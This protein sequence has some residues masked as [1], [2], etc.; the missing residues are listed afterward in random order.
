MNLRHICCLFVLVSGLVFTII[1]CDF[2][3]INSPPDEITEVTLAELLPTAL[4]Q[5]A[6][7]QSALE[8]R[9]T[10]IFSQVLKEAQD[11]SIRPF[12]SYNLAPATFDDYWSKGYYSGS[13]LQARTILE[14]AQKE[15]AGPYEAVAKIILAHEFGALTSEFGDIPFSQAAKGNEFLYPQY[16]TQENVYA[17]I[18]TLLDEAI[19][20]IELGEGAG[21][22]IDDMLYAGNMG[23]WK[24]FAYA[25]KARFLLH[26][27]NKSPDRFMEILEILQTRTFTSMEEQPK[28]DWS[29][30]YIIGLD[31]PFYTFVEERPWTIQVHENFVDRLIANNDPRLEKIAVEEEP[32]RW[33]PYT[34]SDPFKLPFF[35]PMASIPVLSMVEIKFMEAE[36][37]LRTGS[38]F[39]PITAA[40]QDAIHISFT[41]LGLNPSDHA[42]FIASHSNI[43]GLTDEEIL[44]LIMEEA[45]VAYYGY[46][47]GQIWCNF[48]RL[49]LPELSPEGY[50]TEYDPSGSIPVRFLYPETERVYNDENT[51]AAIDRQNGA[52]LDTP[53]WAFE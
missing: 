47:F 16:D 6:Y 1:S 14:K 12:S 50:V 22:G 18:Q 33:L 19:I 41:Q 45:Y 48:R 23:L 35:R 11:I 43:N 51:Q 3:E 44:Q 26:T 4:T 31:N 32:G 42:D 21:P 5:M 2:Q 27:S 40:I 46:A 28:F 53:V 37:L 38:P 13:I 20:L 8:A 36:T 15:N 52:L 9:A 10:G 17:G 30:T 25:L 24:K 49:G 39:E 29:N 34:Y 7:N